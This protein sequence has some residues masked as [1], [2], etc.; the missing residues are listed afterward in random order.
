[1]EFETTVCGMCFMKNVFFYTETV[2][3]SHVYTGIIST[4]AEEKLVVHSESEQ[5]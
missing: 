5:E 2:K 3:M 1:M 4:E